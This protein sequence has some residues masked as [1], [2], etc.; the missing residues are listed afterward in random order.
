L[1]VLLLWAI[2]VF[3]FSP[4]RTITCTRVARLSFLLKVTVTAGLVVVPV[5]CAR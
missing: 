2:G 1:F 3:V 5:P 4:E